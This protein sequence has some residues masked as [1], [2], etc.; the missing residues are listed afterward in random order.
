MK[1]ASAAA[2]GRAAASASTDVSTSIAPVLERDPDRSLDAWPFAA[3]D[4]FDLVARL[5]PCGSERGGRRRLVALVMQQPGEHR[6]QPRGREAG[7]PV[8]ER[9]LDDLSRPL[10]VPGAGERRRE[11]RR[12]ARL[13]KVR[14]PALGLA[15]GTVR[16]RQR[17]V[18][19][20]ARR[21]DRGSRRIELPRAPR[22]PHR[23]RFR[24][25]G[26]G[27]RDVVAP[28]AETRAADRQRD[29][30]PPG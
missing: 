23:R 13:V 28:D 17:A 11:Q 10:W 8:R 7:C 5:L 21:G 16:R 9:V 15:C 3:Y 18:A 24:Q 27:A 30:D 26:L 22:R 19:V 14:P 29:A 20:A 12:A 6:V 1:P 2:P 25:V 4:V